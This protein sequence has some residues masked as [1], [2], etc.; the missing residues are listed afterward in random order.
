MEQVVI[1]GLCRKSMKAR[2][3]KMNEFPMQ[4]DKQTYWCHE[5]LEPDGIRQEDFLCGLSESE[6]W[7]GTYC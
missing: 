2:F 6:I 7:L 4:S 5:N 1:E 3:Q